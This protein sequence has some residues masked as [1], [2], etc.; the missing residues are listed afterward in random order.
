[1]DRNRNRKKR[2][3]ENR[4]RE[5]EREIGREKRSPMTIKKHELLFNGQKR[6]IVKEMEGDRQT[7]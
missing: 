3:R 5:R 4:E 6:Q 2:V 7:Y 1:M